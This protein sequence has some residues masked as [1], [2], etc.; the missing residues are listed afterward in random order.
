MNKKQERLANK[1]KHH[2]QSRLLSNRNTS[3][4]NRAVDVDHTQETKEE[5]W[6]EITSHNDT[7]RQ[8]D[9]LCALGRSK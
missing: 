5:I 2:S 1:H 9:R 4:N 6:K 3:T 8:R 7:E